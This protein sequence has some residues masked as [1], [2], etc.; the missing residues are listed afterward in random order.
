[1]TKT[2]IRT[3]I[4]AAIVAC[5]VWALPA[6]AEPV[7]YVVEPHHTFVNFEVLHNKTSTVR[8]RFDQVDGFIVLDRAA[9][10]GQAEITIDT[11]SVSSG[12][13]AFDAHLKNADFLDVP[14]APKARFV[15]KDFRFDGDKVVSVSGD[16]VLL[17][18]TAPVTLTATRFNCYDSRI[19]KAPV[20]GGDFETEIRRST[21][22]MNWGIEG[23]IPDSVRLLIQIEAIRQ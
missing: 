10:T 21:W 11:G 19:V 23:G 7:R 18:K 13:A 16:L 6:A 17:G 15:G 5:S 22:G 3:A 12:I 4:A 8:A 14:N 2:G 20:C 1:M 9:K